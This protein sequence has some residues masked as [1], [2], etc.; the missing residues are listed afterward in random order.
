ML[1]TVD[2]DR[3]LEIQGDPENRATE[4]TVCLKGIS[5]A[6][7][8]RHPGRLTTPLRR[9]AKGEFDPISWDEALDG[10]ASGLRTIQDESGP[11]AVLY[12]EGSGSHGALSALAD[13]FWRPFGGPTRTHGDL[14][15]PAGLEAT[16]LTYGDNRHNH[17]ALTRESSFILLWGH[18][19]A[20]TNIHQWRFILDA[21]ERGAR[22]AVVD[23]RST[24]STDLA[25]LHLQ[26]RPGTDGA[27]ALGL[28]H[29]IVSEGLH[30][31]PFLTRSSLGFDEYRERIRAF[32]PGRVAEITGLT[33]EEIRELA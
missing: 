21:R 15:W 1:V 17:P 12:Y 18:N 28:G 27:L 2:G 26:P 22:I 33:E 30:D 10:I 11:Q 6:Q 19:P 24:D 16:R 31:E 5:Y 14:C 25:D 7:R 32:P 9:N 8:A 13:A 4:G 23:P 3:I 20:E 29:L